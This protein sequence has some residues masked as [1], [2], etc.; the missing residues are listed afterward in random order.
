MA[1][2][3]LLLDLG[4]IHEPQQTIEIFIIVVISWHKQRRVHIYMVTINGNGERK[5]TCTLLSHGS[6]DNKAAQYTIL[7]LKAYGL[8]AV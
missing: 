2:A 7:L 6:P 5:A 8:H 1:A 4:T 3:E